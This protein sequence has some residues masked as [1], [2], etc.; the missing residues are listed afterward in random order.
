MESLKGGSRDQ[1]AIWR[2]NDDAQAAK[3]KQALQ[4]Y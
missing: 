2:H 3:M 4:S 1:R